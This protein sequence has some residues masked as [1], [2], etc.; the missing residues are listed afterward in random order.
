MSVRGELVNQPS[1]T[2]ERP[3]SDALVYIDEPLALNRRP[4]KPGTGAALGTA[5]DV[6]TSCS[7][8]Y[9]MG[10][11][12]RAERFVGRGACEM[13]CGTYTTDC[14]VPLSGSVDG[15]R[16]RRRRCRSARQRVAQ[17]VTVFAR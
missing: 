10:R 15:R 17:H 1:G 5:I 2:A 8:A 4:A 3:V 14:A 13:P 12:P 6:P 7:N 11:G 9:R 16:I